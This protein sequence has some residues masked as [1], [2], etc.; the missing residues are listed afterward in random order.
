MRLGVPNRQ[1]GLDRTARVVGMHVHRITT[2]AVGRRRRDGDRITE[3]V[4]ALTE[5]L[6]PVGLGSRS[7]GT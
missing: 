2:A 1:R 3:F 7:V 6:D 4:K 5:V